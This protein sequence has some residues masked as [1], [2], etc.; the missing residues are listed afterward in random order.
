MILKTVVGK[1]LEEA[2]RLAKAEYGSI[3]VVDQKKRIVKKGLFGLLGRDEFFEVVFRVEE[4]QPSRSR[5]RSF[6]QETQ[7]APTFV[8]QQALHAIKSIAAKMKTGREGGGG[9]RETPPEVLDELK[10]MR[11]ALDKIVSTKRGGDGTHPQLKFVRRFLEKNDFERHF[12]DE[13]LGEIE[14]GLS[15]K[16]LQ[17]RNEVRIQL[18]EILKRSFTTTLPAS[19]P[20]YPRMIALVGPTGVGKTTTLAKIGAKYRLGGEE[21]DDAQ[22][23]L[24]SMD[25]YRIGSKEQVEE[26]ANIL[27][28]PSRAI[29]QKDD[30]ADILEKDSADVY[31]LDTAGRNQKKE[32]DLGEIRSYLKLINIPLEVFL[33]VSATTKY[34]DLVEIMTN[35]GA[36]GY[37]SVILTK[38]DETN[39]FGSVLSALA[40][41]KQSL[42]YVCMGQR[43]PDDI[44]IA[45]K[46]DL[47]SR[48]MMR[49]PVEVAEAVV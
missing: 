10:E 25:N 13:V 14:E 3:Q 37:N 48:I 45:E 8:H 11:Q 41:A 42:S 19:N 16:Q 43:V 32:L 30:L 17:D 35:F 47:V 24:L 44:K 2:I 9:Y 7:E 21:G 29:H 36:T 6:S 23:M 34:A 26:Y 49:F 38:V 46:S 18:E 31:I 4:K 28:V 39:T 20:E 1:T 5:E 33:V 27:H 15:Y 22:I 12:I 40:E